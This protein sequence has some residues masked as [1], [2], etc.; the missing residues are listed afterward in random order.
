[1]S[2]EGKDQ[3]PA[4]VFEKVVSKNDACRWVMLELSEDSKSVVVAGTGEDFPSFRAAFDPAKVLWGAF[5]V[6]GVDERNSVE[7]VRTK[8][9]QVNWVGESV[10]P[11]KRMK[12]LQGAGL[13]GEVISGTVAVTI[14]AT[15]SDEIDHKDIAIKLANCGGAH[16]PTYYQFGGDEKLSLADIGKDVAGDGF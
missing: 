11:M 1:M 14:E 16:K 3:S 8:V 15:N 10:K 12:A 9:V 7:S 13:A 4:D 2:G 5:N 6:H